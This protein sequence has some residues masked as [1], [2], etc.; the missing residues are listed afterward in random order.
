MRPDVAIQISREIIK[1][2]TPFERS[3]AAEMAAIDILKKAVSNNKFN[4]SESKRE[5]LPK[6]LKQIEAIPNDQ[7]KF[8]SEMLERDESGKFDPKKY[9]L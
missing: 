1:K 5:W 9:D 2:N 6:M 8:I 3:R 4:I 7:E